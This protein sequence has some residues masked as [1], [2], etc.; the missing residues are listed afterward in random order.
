M[1][2]P[3]NPIIRPQMD[4][5]MG[6]N[7]NGPSLVRL[8]G[9]Y[10]LYFAAHRDSYIR[11]AVSDDLREWRTVRDGVL[12]LA[13]TP[14][15]DHIASPDVHVVRGEV[16]MY[17]HGPVGGGRPQ[18][19]RVATSGD[20]LR[21]ECRPEIVGLAYFRVWAM[22]GMWYALAMPGV[23]YR[24]ADG[25]TGFEQGPT[26][27][28]RNMR[29]S[30]VLLRDRTLHVLYSNAGDAPERIL[31][32]TIDVSGD[33]MSWAASHPVVLLEP[34]EEWEGASLP[35]EAS[36]RGAIHE[37][38]RQLRDPAIFED[39]DGSLSLLYSVAGESG[40]AIAR[41]EI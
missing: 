1:R 2:L 29:H 4:D 25:L 19:T 27:F 20:G 9:R 3:G 38:A 6:S 15:V 30:A 22:D 16:R 14:F 13:D 33:W 17:F 39:D 11:L 21:F 40:I 10:H 23:L 37:P 5:R 31:H 41:L 24:S 32:A 35:V 7:I 8:N 34:E 18:M 36:V 26:L 12:D 28:T